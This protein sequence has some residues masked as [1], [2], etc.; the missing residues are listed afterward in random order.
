MG[1]I[2]VVFVFLHLMMVVSSWDVQEFDSKFQIDM[3]MGGFEIISPLLVGVVPLRSGSVHK[4]LK[5]NLGMMVQQF[6]SFLF[7]DEICRDLLHEEIYKGCLGVPFG[8]ARGLA[9]PQICCS[10]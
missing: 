8:A 6:F 3:N 1:T 4:T 10:F 7:G 5:I 2:S 9:L